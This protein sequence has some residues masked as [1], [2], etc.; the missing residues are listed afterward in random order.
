MAV[1]MKAAARAA[2]KEIAADPG[3]GV[4]EATVIVELHMREVLEYA[5]DVAQ[6]WATVR[7]TMEGRQ[8]VDDLSRELRAVMGAA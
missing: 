5:L 3:G 4:R 8:A 1:S 6:I 2:A 7:G